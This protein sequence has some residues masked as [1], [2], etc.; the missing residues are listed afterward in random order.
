MCLI[1]I[2]LLGVTFIVILQ[3]IQRKEEKEKVNKQKDSIMP[4][5]HKRMIS[6]F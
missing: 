5:L 2:I 3:N 1:V 6:Y 4:S